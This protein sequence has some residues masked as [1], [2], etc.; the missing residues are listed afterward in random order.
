[1]T[2]AGRGQ[3]RRDGTRPPLR[4]G[5]RAPGS[6]GE[7]G[8]FGIP[9]EIKPLEEGEGRRSRHRSE[10]RDHMPA[11]SATPQAPMLCGRPSRQ[12]A[13]RR[14]GAQAPLGVPGWSG[15]L[16]PGPSLRASPAVRSGSRPPATAGVVRAYGS[17]CSRVWVRECACVYTSVRAGKLPAAQA[18]L[19]P[20][21]SF[22]VPLLNCSPA[23]LPSAPCG[24]PQ[25][26]F[27][28]SLSLGVCSGSR[29]WVPSCS[30]GG[31]LL[32]PASTLG[33]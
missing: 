12:R 21:T 32:C 7:A 9:P 3:A 17:V 30:E 5:E 26:S 27:P 22:V 8:R 31:H 4:R 23:R 19:S 13:G 1:M 16:G 6:R 29:L 24:C 2:G 25:P 20:S 14:P 11:G 10:L 15:G 18:R 33:L 28:A